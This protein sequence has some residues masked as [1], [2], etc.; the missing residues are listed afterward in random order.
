MKP[1]LFSLLTLFLL[2]GLTALPAAA[3][4]VR[5]N[6]SVPGPRNLGQYFTWT[7]ENVSGTYASSIYHY[8]V[9]DYKEIGDHYSYWSVNWGQWFNETPEHGKKFVAVW[10]RGWMEGTTY[11][12]WGQD[13]F[14][15]WVNGQT[16]PADPVKLQ[17]IEIGSYTGAGRKESV[18]TAATSSGCAPTPAPV[19][20]Q[21]ANT[22][23]GWSR[24][25][26]W[27]PVVIQQVEYLKANNERGRLTTERFGW[28]DENEYTRMEPGWSAKYDGFLIYQVPVN[29]SPE[30]M[31]I[32]GNFRNYGTAIW[33]LTNT[34]ITQE[35]VEIYKKMETDLMNL[36]RETG[37]RLPDKEPGRSEA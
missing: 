8:T 3:E 2:I 6:E 11:F 16:I 14:N 23:S 31:S 34:T 30:G 21:N 18:G 28:K 26:R 27:L 25:G 7:M 20:N 35:S 13:R 12:G 37:L 10:V 9:Y 32:A 22:G 15:L 33:H 29:S 36:Q 4:Q 24:T 19:Q 1:I 17:D 5:F